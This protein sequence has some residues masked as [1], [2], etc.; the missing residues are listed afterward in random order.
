VRI[1]T[2]RS[3]DW[4]IGSGSSFVWAPPGT[5]AAALAATVLSAPGPAQVRAALRPP[6]DA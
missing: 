1:R 5:T 2:A 4:I 6:S 3:T